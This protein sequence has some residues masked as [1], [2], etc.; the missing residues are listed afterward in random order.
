[1][2]SS[3]SPVE[4][5]SG[6]YAVPDAARLLGVSNGTVRQWIQAVG[7][8][9]R[10]ASDHD[11]SVVDFR[12]LVELHLVGILAR[13]GVSLATITLLIKAA[14]DRLHADYPLSYERFAKEADIIIDGLT[15]D[16]TAFDAD[17]WEHASQVLRSEAAVFLKALDFGEDGEPVR[18]WPKN[19]RGRIVLDTARQ[20]GQPIDAATGVPTWAIYAAIRAGNGQEPQVVAE[21][22][23]LPLAAV[24]AAVA[25]EESLAA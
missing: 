13:G 20:R 10:Q 4:I 1:M 24:I 8:T 11:A 15:R 18:Y 5:G 2:A 3:V 7:A 23:N 22:F 14:R 16:V 17:D 19:G 6:I 25:F 12:L 9:P 21:W